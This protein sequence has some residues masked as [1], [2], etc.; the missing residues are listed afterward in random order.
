MNTRESPRLAAAQ[1]ALAAAMLAV[2]VVLGAQAARRETPTVDEFAHLPAGLAALRHGDFAIYPQNPPLARLLMALPVALAGAA[3]PPP[4]GREG[5]DWE[6]WIYGHRF[7][8]INRDSYLR[9]FFLARLAVAMLSAAGGLLLFCWA[10]RRYGRAAALAALFLY[11][12]CPNLAAHGRLATVDAIFTTFALAAFFALDRW[13]V[14]PRPWRLALAGASF[15]LALAT[16]F[17]AVVLVPVIAALLIAALLRRQGLYRGMLSAAGCGAVL[18]VVALL[19]VAAAYGFQVPLQPLGELS[20]A[21]NAGRRLTAVLPAWLPLPLPRDFISGLDLQTLDV[22]RGEFGA[23]FAGRWYDRSPALAIAALLVFKTPLATLLLLAAAAVS[24]LRRPRSWLEEAFV[25]LPPVSLIAVCALGSALNP[26]VRYLLPA[27]PF[28]FLGISRLFEGF[29]PRSVKGALLVA[30]LAAVGLEAAAAYPRQLSYFNALAGG[31]AGGHHW[32]IDSNLDW[33]QDLAAVKPY[34]A[35]RGQ[36]FVYLLYFG[37]V[38]PDIYGIDY[39][40]PPPQLRPGLYVVSV[41]FAKGYTYLAPDHGRMV[42]ATGGAPEWLRQRPPDDRIGESLWVY[43][44][45]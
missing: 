37:H 16:K 44:V 34:L 21:S 31:L 15:D 23:Y 33:G 3:T 19:I 12:S 22:E 2:S 38:E 42:R 25:W 30:G 6:P 8:E 27:L 9:L 32:F 40:L 14:S 1:Y 18:G 24:V 7:L 4:L 13:R 20:F 17:T 35:A 36:D 10:H 41:N 26:A 43:V 29:A 5:R 39:A 45:P 28:L 11:L